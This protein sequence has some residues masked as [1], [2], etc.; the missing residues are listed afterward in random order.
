MSMRQ[1]YAHPLWEDKAIVKN[2]VATSEPIDLTDLAGNGVFSLMVK[3]M[4]GALSDVTF[5]YTMCDTK[6]GTYLT[7]DGA[8]DIKANLIGGSTIL[9]SFEPELANFIRIVATENNVAAVT[10]LTAVLMTQ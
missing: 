2:A 6:T 10:A 3:E 9:I 7:P 5:T 8:V 4:A 1:V